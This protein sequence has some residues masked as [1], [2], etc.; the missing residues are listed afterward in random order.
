MYTYK[1]KH[2]S[3]SE[4]SERIH[5]ESIRYNFLEDKYRIVNSKAFRRL[6]YKTQVFINYIGDHYRTRLTH[7]LEVSQIAVYIS[8]VLGLNENLTETIALS[9]DIGHPPFGHAGEEALNKAAVNFGGFDHNI[10]TIKI[11]S[12]IEKISVQYK[13]LNLTK[14]TIDGILKHNGPIKNKKKKK[15]TRENFS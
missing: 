2:L 11:I 10:Q 8:K 3:I 13:G 5:K 12:I 15:C 14:D 7:S 6:E 1:L 4:N 9:H